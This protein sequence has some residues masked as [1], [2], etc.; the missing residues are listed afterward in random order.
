MLVT[1]DIFLESLRRVDSAADLTIDLETTGLHPWL[2]DR[3]IGVAVL[4]DGFPMYFPFRH[5]TDNLHL[6]GLPALI[7]SFEQHNT[8]TGFNIKFDHQF[9]MQEGMQLPAHVNDPMLS[10]H[11]V[12]ENEP[13]HA[14]KTLSDKYL[15]PDSSKEQRNLDLLLHNAKLKKNEMGHLPPEQVSPYAEMDVILTAKLRDFYAPKLAHWGLTELAEEVFD[16]ELVLT[17]M[18]ANGIAIDPER[19]AQ[20]LAECDTKTAEAVTNLRG[21]ANNEKLNPNSAIQL[22]RMLRLSSTAAAYLADAIAGNRLDDQQLILV[23]ALQ[24][25]RGWARAASAYYQPY[26]DLR[27]ENDVLHPNYLMA[28]VITGRLSCNDPNLMAI[29]RHDDRIV[30]KVKDVFVARDPRCSLMNADYSQAELRLLA[31][32]TQD[33]KMIA[34]FESGED[35][36]GGTAREF[37]IPRYAAKRVNFGIAYGLGNQG[38]ADALHCS[39][40]DAKSILDT[41]HRGRPGIRQLMNKAESTAR[42][43]GYIRMWTGR[44]S[45]FNT[46]L[47]D[48][49]KAM[50]T[51][52]QGGVAEIMRVKLTELDKHM[53]RFGARMLI[54]VHDSIMFEIP[55]ENR[56][57]I[58]AFI[59]ATMS[60]LP[61]DCPFLV[62][63]EVGK[64][65]GS[66]QKVVSS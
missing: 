4:A 55:D 65:W 10:S 43:R 51:L 47:R 61:F 60:D 58:I 13:S 56:E 2:G 8:H 17:R 5:D 39:L 53:S 25:Y 11:L 31:H 1:Q 35:F 30:G 52:I 37:G 48:P 19:T 46:H 33:A 18:E 26:L 9:L 27:D 50:S 22:Q 3:L 38:L 64:R 6:S 44:V 62:D 12:N 59:R 49:H 21:L 66:A 23:D 57:E 32:Y 15:G 36:H 54:Q 40:R 20:Y 14:L 42:S 29:P 63:V 28:R 41:Y 7:R 34:L 24:L 45:R 16:Y